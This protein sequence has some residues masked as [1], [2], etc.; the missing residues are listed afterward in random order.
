MKQTYFDQRWF[1]NEK[2]ADWLEKG[3][4]SEHFGCKYCKR[5]NLKL[6][7]MGVR[8]LSSH[9]TGKKH[10]DA[11]KVR[12]EVRSFFSKHSSSSVSKSDNSVNNVESENVNIVVEDE[13]VVENSTEKLQSTITHAIESSLVLKAEIIW[14]L[15]LIMKDFSNN[16]S[17]DINLTFQEIFEDSNIAK[18]FHCGPDKVKYLTNWGIAPWVKEMLCNRVDKSSFI[19]VSFDESLNETF[20]SKN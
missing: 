8:A 20:F 1:N 3:I 11:A 4:D 12:T 14:T 7:N 15:T 16:S 18:N 9:I 2:V 13:E 6:S 10:K 19:V 5:K 17:K